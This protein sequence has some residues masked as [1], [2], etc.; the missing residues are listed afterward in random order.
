MN[1]QEAIVSVD[2]SLPENNPKRGCTDSSPGEF[3][4]A[5][6]IPYYNDWSEVFDH[7]VQKFWITSWVCTDTRVG[8][9]L[10][11]LDGIPVAVSHQ[12]A[13]KNDERIEFLSAADADRMRA[14][15]FDL[16]RAEQSEPKLCNLSQEID[17]DWWGRGA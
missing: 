1:W 8:L 7:R 14:L 4:K 2:Y 5:L 3:A 13:R 11:K 10:Y 9:A 16:L 12:S 17:A 15:I 6:D